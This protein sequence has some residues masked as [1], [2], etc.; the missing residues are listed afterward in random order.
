MFCSEC[1][2]PAQGK[3]CCHCGSP[4]ALPIAAVEPAADLAPIE[5]V[6]DWDHE[7]RYETILKFPGVRSKIER[8]A[9]QAPKRMSGEKFLSLADKVMQVGVPMEGMAVAAQALWSHLGI[10]TGKQRA[11]QVA[12]PAGQVLVRALCSLAR[13]GQSLRCVTQADDG[14]LLEAA[15]PSDLFSLEG[16]LLV[17]VRR[18]GKLAQVDATTHIAGQMMDW[19]KSNRALDQLFH[20][21]SRDA[22]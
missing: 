17:S 21:L 14:C 10:K 13:H 16:D 11:Q 1:G 18:A 6:P 12:A 7:I 3:F 4:L 22:A 5:L 2:K 8:H 9:S 20:D 15:L 19:G